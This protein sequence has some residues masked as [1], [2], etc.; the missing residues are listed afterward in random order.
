[1]SV[2]YAL[3]VKYLDSIYCDEDC[4]EKEG[5]TEW[6]HFL[7]PAMD[8]AWDITRISSIVIRVILV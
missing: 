1:M 2:E 3:F 8:T 5:K 6:W 4:S 7:M